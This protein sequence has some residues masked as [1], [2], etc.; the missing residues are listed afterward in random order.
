MRA[1]RS[2]MRHSDDGAWLR[3]SLIDCYQQLAVA[4]LV[5]RE[6]RH[7]IERIKG[8]MIDAVVAAKPHVSRRDTQV[9]KERREIRSG[10]K[11]PNVRFGVV[12]RIS[13]AALFARAILPLLIDRL[14]GL[15]IPHVTRRG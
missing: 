10:T 9:L 4:S 11:S 8:R 15:W 12:V 1:P 5:L 3:R 14:A 7:P 6:L 13:F 2:S